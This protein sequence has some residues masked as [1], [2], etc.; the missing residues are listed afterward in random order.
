M[1][2]KDFS[3]IGEQIS[4]S[5]Q[6]AIDSMD[7][8]QLNRNITDTVNRALGEAKKQI[9]NH[10]DLFSKDY[11]PR[12]EKYDK[13][14]SEQSESGRWDTRGQQTSQRVFRPQKAHAPVRIIRTNPVGKT[15]G[16]LFTVFGGIALGLTLCAA[17]VYMIWSLIRGG[18]YEMSVA[19]LGSLGIFLGISFVMLTVGSTLRGRIKRLQLYLTGL[20]G[21]LYCPIQEL[22]EKTGRKKQYVSKDLRRMIHDGF[23]PEAYLDE[24]GTCL[25]LDSQTYRQYQQTQEAYQKQ[26]EEKKKGK[27]GK[28]VKTEKLSEVK[29][30]QADNLSPELSAVMKEGERCIG[31]LREA[32]EALPG[33]VISD[34]LI[35][36]ES[37]IS[38]IFESVKKNPEQLG[39][40]Q[41]FMDYYLPT[42]IKLV[43]AYREFDIA[44]L[45]GE[46]I[47]TAKLEIER[48]LDT[49]NHA[50]AR[51]LDDLYQDAALDVSTDASVLQTMLEKDGWMGSDFNQEEK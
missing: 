9:G 44:G 13:K 20:N 35:R 11:P 45:Q 40:M 33:A 23:L 42:T 7:F 37:I 14:V 17:L 16:I 29:P 21:R 41:R 6:N 25:I 49:I 10:R 15:A 46:N 19:V 47:K 30:E 1:D 39:D 48:T 18:S 38:R 24:K 32:N 12:P 3:N 26:L 5:V 22:A 34:K 43:N 2:N 4:N 31:L 28:S 50:F 8:Q 51:L 27:L 36:L